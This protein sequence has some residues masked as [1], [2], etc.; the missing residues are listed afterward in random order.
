MKKLQRTAN[1]GLYGSLL[2]SLL[3]VCIYYFWNY[4]F[5]VNEGGFRF[6]T[7]AGCVLAVLTLAAI[8]FTVRKSVPRIR[9]LDSI[10]ERLK[11]YTE[12]TS[13]IYLTTL[14]VVVVE[15]VFITFS[16]NSV[17]FMLLMVM[18]LLLFLLYPNHYRIKVDLG[19]T[20]EEWEQLENSHQ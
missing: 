19:L 5:Y 8:L 2:I 6:M 16:H 3:T 10:D 9:Q 7:V 17:L 1:I 13:N 18:V 11:R 15:C 12:Q 14:G 4:R 20:D